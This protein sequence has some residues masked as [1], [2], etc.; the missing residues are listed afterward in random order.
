MKPK[1]LTDATLDEIEELAKSN[2]AET[3]RGALLAL[4]EEVR[5]LRGMILDGRESQL[6]NPLVG[7]EGE[8]ERLGI[9]PNSGEN[10]P[11]RKH[12]NGCRDRI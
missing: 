5:R 2:A 11:L 6:R 8:V 4:V 1:P 10:S 7:R 3:Y 9:S 12:S